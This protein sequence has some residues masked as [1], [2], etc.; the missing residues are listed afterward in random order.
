MPRHARLHYP[1]GIYHLISRFVNRSYLIKTDEDRNQYLRLLGNASGKSDAIILGY[2]L[3]SSHVH[4]VVRAGSDSLEGL[5]KSVNAGFAGWINRRSK[6]R[7]G[8]VFMER[9]KSILVDEEAYLVE[10]VRYVHTDGD[11]SRLLGELC[12]L[13]GTQFR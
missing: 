3:M 11:G 1:G 8:P 9:Y 2:C 5:M 12:F 7:K 13:N 6:R 4:L 10:L